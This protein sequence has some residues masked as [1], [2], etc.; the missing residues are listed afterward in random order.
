V[1]VRYPFLKLR[2][3]KQK[4]ILVPFHSLAQ[5]RQ[6]GYFPLW[7]DDMAGELGLAGVREIIITNILHGICMQL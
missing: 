7:L 5:A 6:T 4:K 2:R 1:V 3:R